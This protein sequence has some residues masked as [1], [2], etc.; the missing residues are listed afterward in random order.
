MD[1]SIQI[2]RRRGKRFILICTMVV[3]LLASMVNEGSA[4]A[5][6]YSYD[7]LNR[8]VN[9]AYETGFEEEYTYDGVVYIFIVN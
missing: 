1:S 2:G 4:A 7:N 3:A 5:L 9:V 6:A 8:L